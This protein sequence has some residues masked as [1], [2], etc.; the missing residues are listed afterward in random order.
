MIGRYSTFELS[1]DFNRMLWDI[2]IHN[3]PNTDDNIYDDDNDE[4]CKHWALNSSDI[5]IK[6]ELDTVSVY[7]DKQFYS[8]F[9]KENILFGCIGRSDKFT[10]SSAYYIV[11]L[12]QPALLFVRKISIFD[13][14]GQC[15]REFPISAPFT[16]VIASGI[17]T[18]GDEIIVRKCC[19]K[20]KKKVILEIYTWF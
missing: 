18:S 19:Y 3:N 20:F 13:I 10:Q 6:T 14:H 16:N 9:H 5:Y 8:R 2:P 17:F 15:V 12:H 7:I 11:V 1:Q 4:I